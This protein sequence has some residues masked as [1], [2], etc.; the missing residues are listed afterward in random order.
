M[1]LASSDGLARIH[2][3]AFLAADAERA[4]YVEA[5]NTSGDAQPRLYQCWAKIEALRFPK[6]RR[7]FEFA[8]L[9]PRDPE[10]HFGPNWQHA[11]ELFHFGGQTLIEALNQDE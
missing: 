5:S 1:G 8:G 11:D 7:N 4:L 6:L 3:A 9:A 10:D 2:F